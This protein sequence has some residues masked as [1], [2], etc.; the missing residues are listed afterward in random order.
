MNYQRIYDALI[1]KAQNREL[2]IPYSENHHIIPECLGGVDNDE[3]KVILTAREHY[4]AHILLVYIYPDNFKIWF[5]LNGMQRTNKWQ[6]RHNIMPDFLKNRFSKIN[7]S[8]QKE[9]LKNPENHPM[10]GKKQSEE[11]KIKNRES[12]R[13]KTWNEV[14][15][16]EKADKKRR[17]LSKLFKIPN[18]QRICACGCLQTFECKETS[19]QKCIHGHQSKEHRE[20]IRLALT[21]MKYR[22][23]QK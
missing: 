12:Q 7:S 1:I 5:A 21:G 20:K 15:G 6:H 10:F 23:C 3:N 13:G 14:L 4:F 18:E 17:L 19:K 22:K 16:K 2:L 11:S 9:W 8:F